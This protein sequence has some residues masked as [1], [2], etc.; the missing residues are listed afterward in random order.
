MFESL[1][2]LGINLTMAP[3]PQALPEI[4]AAER[5]IPD[6]KRLI[7]RINDVRNAVAENISPSV[8]CFENAI[9][10]LIDVDNETQGELGVIYMLRYAS[11][12]QAARDASN[13]ATSLLG[14]ASSEFT[15]R[16]DLYLIV[17]AVREK[18]EKLEFEAA[19]YLQHLFQDFTRCGHGVLNG[20][21]IKTYLD[22]RDEI[23]SLRR[24]YT[25]NIRDDDGGLWLSLEELGGVS[26][27]D[28]LFFH[29][30]TEPETQ[31]M[32]FVHF[33]RADL[34]IIMKFAKNPATRKKMY[35]A[36]SRKLAQNVELFK[37]VILLRDENARL[38]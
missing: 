3:S 18:A 26:E 16:A 4:I 20:D 28:I 10:P 2:L 25:R 34:E 8:A 36:N 5:I 38:L 35:I 27:Q 23:D 12:D 33:T 37:E 31:G 17:K 11:P 6:T 9:Q 24:K 29:E 19:K 7:G 32:R 30:G 22:R 13:E 21:E 15:A 14:K 1:L